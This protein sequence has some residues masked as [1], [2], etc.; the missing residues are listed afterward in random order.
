MPSSI[1]AA[2]TPYA[3]SG[4]RYH[5]GL[6]PVPVRVRRRRVVVAA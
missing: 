6:A 2:F 4:G 5:W 3:Y 1:F